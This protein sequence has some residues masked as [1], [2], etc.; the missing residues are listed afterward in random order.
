MK[1]MY[2]E[3][4]CPLCFLYSFLNIINNYIENMSD[5]GPKQKKTKQKKQEWFSAPVLSLFPYSL[6]EAEQTTA[7]LHH[8]PFSL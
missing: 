7:C 6:H 4:I 3:A 5:N 2:R 8:I 1:Y